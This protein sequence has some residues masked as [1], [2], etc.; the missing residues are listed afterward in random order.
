MNVINPLN[1]LL[2]VNIVVCTF[3]LR[4]AFERADVRVFILMTPQKSGQ[5]QRFSHIVKLS[6]ENLICC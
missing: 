6:W 1:F 2:D 4:T 3:S 5:S